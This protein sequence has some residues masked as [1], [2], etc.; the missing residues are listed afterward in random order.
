MTITMNISNIKTVG[1]I[2]DFL[3]RSEP[4]ELSPSTKVE[5]YEWL[6]K[7][8]HSVHYV[9]LRKKEKKLVKQFIKK[10][11]GY[12]DVQI[13]RLIKKY[14]QG[15]LVWKQWQNG[16]THRIY[17]YEDIELLHRVDQEHRLSGKATK[18]ILKREYEVF[19][20]DEFRKLANISVAHIYNLR[21]S[22]SY[23]RKGN[24]F[25][26]TKTRF[27]PIGKRMKPQPNGK[28]GFFRVDSVHQG[29]LGGKKGVYF[30]NIVDEITQI[31]F[32]F[33]VEAISQKYITSVLN[34]LIKLCPFKVIN[35][36]SDNGSEYINYVIAN[37]LNKLHIKQTKS[38]ARKHNDNALVES[39][40]GS[41]IRKQ[42]G[43]Y[44]IPATTYNAHILTSF[45]INWLNPYL[46]FH[47][48]CG[49]A[50]ITIDK[51]GKQRKVYNTYMT[52]YEKL[53]SIDNAEQYLVD[54]TTFKQL[55]LITQAM[56]DTEF[57]RKMNQ[58][59]QKMK[60]KL[61]F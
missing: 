41:I 29:D 44:H 34:S 18:E 20:K 27:I 13:K 59:K 43:Y 61:K 25:D 33:C 9:K 36:H 60:S 37:L 47:R 35:F 15:N 10:V 56:S 22:V 55:D 2:S 38:R 53:K 26:K 24:L 23:Q 14:K 57:C 51:K 7:L 54:K 16:N 1:Q 31:E 30:I 28:P 48:P 3:K 39:K 6:N 21:G 45:C 40:N 42:F 17:T 8:F 49:F 46:N 50:T 11:A 5:I 19:E 52:P 4:W 32:V 12:S 58:E